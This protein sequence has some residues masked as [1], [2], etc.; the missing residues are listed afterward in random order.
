MNYPTLLGR[1]VYTPS[2]AAR[3]LGLSSAKLRRWSSD[4]ELKALWANEFS[5]FFE[6]SEL[7]FLDIQQA[8]VISAFRHAGVSLQSI[9]RALRSASEILGTPT[10]FAHSDIQ[11]DGRSLFLKTTDAGSEKVL[12]DLLKSQYTFERI[13]RPTFKDIDF[14]NKVASRWWP[15]SRS[16][17]VV[18]DPRRSF[19]RPVDVETGVE[20]EVLVSAVEAEGGVKEAAAAFDVPVA[21]VKA[22][23][24]FETKLAA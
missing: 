7:S 3:L 9:R 10:P 22:A 14:D 5:Q 16:R 19:G 4:D 24:E 6:T 21:A 18:I 15:L 12:V 1:G 11:T 23:I 20:T 2:E 17:R 8:R 13:I